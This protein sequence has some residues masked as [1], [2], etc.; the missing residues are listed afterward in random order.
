LNAKGKNVDMSYFYAFLMLEDKDLK[1]A[2]RQLEDIVDASAGF[3]TV[4]GGAAA[5]RK[6]QNVQ[7]VVTMDIQNLTKKIADSAEGLCEDTQKAITRLFS[8]SPTY[9]D[10]SFNAKSG[11]VSDSIAVSS[12]YNSAKEDKLIV[13]RKL[14]CIKEQMKFRKYVLTS[15]F[16]DLEEKKKAKAELENIMLELNEM[17][18]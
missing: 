15:D 8:P 17:R 10:V 5:T 6:K 16:Y 7:E 18:K 14:L 2:S 4:G 1:F 9:S 12:S 13:E 11:G 3:G